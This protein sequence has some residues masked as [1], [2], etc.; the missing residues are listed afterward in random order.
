MDRKFHIIKE[1]VVINMNET[2]ELTISFK[3]QTQ[4]IFKAFLE[5]RVFGNAQAHILN[6]SGFATEIN[7]SQQKYFFSF[8]LQI[9]SFSFKT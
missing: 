5:I 7:H 1:T 3:S 8:V 2:K 9:A 6:L 4:G